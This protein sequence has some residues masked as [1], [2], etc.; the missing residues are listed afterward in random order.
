MHSLAQTK[1]NLQA[2]RVVTAAALHRPELIAGSRFN[3]ATIN[4]KIL[5]LACRL[6]M[7]EIEKRLPPYPPSVWARVR[8]E[9]PHQMPAIG[10]ERR[11]VEH[12]AR[13]LRSAEVD[14]ALA[15]LREVNH[16][17]I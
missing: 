3:P 8:C 9:Y 13:Y 15:D 14:D 11:E 17:A 5:R 1:I 4:S 7:A 10:C 16:A 2:A 12:A 6:A